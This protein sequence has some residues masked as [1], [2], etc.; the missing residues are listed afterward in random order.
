[1]LVKMT[2]FQRKLY[3]TFMNEVIRSKKVQN[4]LKAFAVCCKIWNHPDVLYN[5][6]KKK[7]E[8]D[9]EF[10]LEENDKSSDFKKRKID[11]TQVFNETTNSSFSSGSFSSTISNN[12]SVN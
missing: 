6:L 4:P 5:F 3:D 10:E 8:L 12:V 9:L 2:G 7:E 11:N 1:M